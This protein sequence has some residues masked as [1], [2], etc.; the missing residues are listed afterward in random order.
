MI[1]LLIVANTTFLDG[2]GRPDG[3][4]RVWQ[5]EVVAKRTTLSTTEVVGKRFARGNFGVPLFVRETR[6]LGGRRRRCHHRCLRFV[7]RRRLWLLQRGSRGG[8]DHNSIVVGVSVRT[9]VEGVPGLRLSLVSIASSTIVIGIV[10]RC[11]TVGRR[12]RSAM[13]VNGGLVV[14][15]GRGVVLSLIHI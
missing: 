14:N 7:V 15:G 6:R 9:V 8:R 10:L 1:Q 2:D 3:L 12:G 5:R 13:V 11:T 4:S